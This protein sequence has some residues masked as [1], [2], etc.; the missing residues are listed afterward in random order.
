MNFNICV[1]TRT[2]FSGCIVNP[3]FR[4]SATVAIIFLKKISKVSPS[5]SESS[6]YFVDKYP[7]DFIYLN[8]VTKTFVKTLTASE[9]PLGRTIYR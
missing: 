1:V 9:K 6:T 5:N 3:N 2:N 7:F 8:G 4:K